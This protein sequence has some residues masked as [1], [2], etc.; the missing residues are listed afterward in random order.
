MPDILPFPE[1]RPD[2]TPYQG[3]GSTTIKNVVPRGDGYGPFPSFNALSTS[4]AE[5]NDTYT[6]VLLHF[7][8]SDGA[9]TITDSNAG[10]SAH[11]W[12]AAGN[13]QI[14]T[15]AYKFGGASLLCDGTGDWVSTSDHADFSLG[16]GDFTIDCWFNVSAGSGGPKYIAGQA[17]TVPDAS[18][19]S[20]LILRTNANVMEANVYAA[21]VPTGITGTTQFT[22]ATNTG[23]H[24]LAFVRT[25]NTLKL[26]ID[27]VQEGSSTTFS[28]TVTNSANA[29]AVGAAGEHTSNPWEG[30]IDEF[31][32]SVGIARWTTTFSPPGKPYDAASNG[33]CRGYFYA[34]NT[35]GSITVFA[36]T[37]TRLFKLNN[38]A[39]DWDDVSAGGTAYAALPASYHWQFAQFGSLVIAVKPSTAPQV[40]TLGSSTAFGALSGSPPQAAYI[41]VVGRFVVLSGLTSNPFR[42]AWSAL[43]DATGWTAG[44]GLSD[45]QDLPDGGIVR[46]VA[47]GEYGVIFQET[48]MR[49]MI[50]AP[51]SSVVFAIERI[52]QDKGL[53]APY[54][55]IRAGERI[56]FLATTGFHALSPTGYPEPIGKERFDRTFFDSYDSANLQL[57]IGASDPTQT[58]V[59][60]AFKTAS[61]SGSLFDRLLCYDYGLNRATLIEVSGEYLASLAAPGITLESLDSISS[62]IDALTLS[63]DDISTSALAKLSAVNSDHK[64]GFFSGAAIEATLDTSERSADGRRARVKGLRP[65]T[66]AT[67]C[68][69]T[70]GYRETLQAAVAYSTEQAVNG[71]G[72][73]PANISTRLARARL[74][75][76][77]S[78]AWTFATGFE[79]EFAPE[80]KR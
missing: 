22:N 71:K 13:A 19:V 27:G 14:D 79:P 36:G 24:H 54:S 64:I 34:R 30:W 68:Y 3:A 61:S 38:T 50:F 23:W 47:G 21:G 20:F 55:L 80:G 76:P 40:F 63:L 69:G 15:A 16:S 49:R 2:L 72:L 41:A 17:N 44:T 7:D 35:D 26:F 29:L 70:V 75:I 58:R 52:A 48:T 9:T 37:S 57:V 42:I 53:L 11:T 62:S 6:K 66:D 18:S 77:A 32:I 46:G 59:Y 45:T 8:G 33:V 73:C 65:V 12:T 10:G 60:W 28:G 25:G 74:R 39:L 51:G 5:G 78:T 4:L 67:T 56:F 31:R 43:G 1:W